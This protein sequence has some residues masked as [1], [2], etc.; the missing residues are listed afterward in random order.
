MDFFTV[1]TLTFGALYAAAKAAR[2]VHARKRR[3]QPT[4]SSH[5]T[6]TNPGTDRFPACNYSCHSL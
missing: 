3:S 6:E 5:G 2:E 4:T 1:P